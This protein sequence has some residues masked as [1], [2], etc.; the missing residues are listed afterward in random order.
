MRREE[1]L[2][3]PMRTSPA[4][5]QVSGLVRV[6]DDGRNDSTAHEVNALELAEAPASE[7]GQDSELVC[8]IHAG[9]VKDNV[10]LGQGRQRAKAF[11]ALAE[12]PNHIGPPGRELRE[13]DGHR[14]TRINGDGFD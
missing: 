8:V 4:V 5:L 2:L 14:S 10:Q 13:I 6:V 12:R 9:A 7:H 3:L 11:E 1:V